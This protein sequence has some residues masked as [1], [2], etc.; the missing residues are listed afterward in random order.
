MRKLFILLGVLGIT[1]CSSFSS[2][3]VTQQYEKHENCIERFLRLGVNP[4]D[5][6]AICNN[7]HGEE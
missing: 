3:V 1:G 2:K 6:N 7:I 5:S 4:S